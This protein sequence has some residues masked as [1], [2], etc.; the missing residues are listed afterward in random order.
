MLPP[1]ELLQFAGEEGVG[2]LERR[3]EKEMGFPSF[4]KKSIQIP[5]G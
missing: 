5:L 2:P 1:K 3:L 4:L